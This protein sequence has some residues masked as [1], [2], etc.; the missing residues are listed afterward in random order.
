MRIR[1]QELEE[2]TNTKG[3]KIILVLRAILQLV[4]GRC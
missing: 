3:K 2:L 1:L 4:I